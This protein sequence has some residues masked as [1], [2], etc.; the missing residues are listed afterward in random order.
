[1]RKLHRSHVVLAA[2]FVC[3][4]ATAVWF[5][6]SS[7]SAFPWHNGDESNYGLQTM[8]V[9]R[10]EPVETRTPNR[11]LLNPYLLL[12][13]GPFLL[14]AGPS[15]P[16]M[17]APAVVCGL[18]AVILTIVWGARV[19]DRT[20]GLVGGVLVATLPP[21]IF[22]SR[23]GLEQSQLPLFGLFVV[24][25]ALRGHGAGL[26]ATF[27]ASML[28]HPTAIF[29]IP[30]ALP[31]YLVQVARRDE[32]DLRRRRR[33]LIV[34]GVLA[35]G[36]V[37]V[38]SIV[39][40]AHPMTQ[41]RLASR[42]PL[43]WRH[44]LDGCER[45]LFLLYSPTS[46]TNV[47]W[48]RLIFRALL[49][50]LLLLGAGRLV[51]ERRWERVALVGGLAAGLAGFH[52]V[53]GPEV[54]RHEPT[55]RYGVVFLLPTALAFACLIRALVPTVLHTSDVP[56]SPRVR[57]VPLAIALCLGSALLWSGYRNYFGP[58]LREVGESLWTFRQDRRDEYERLLLAI[59]HDR[60]SPE[61]GGDRAGATID[62]T[63]SSLV[64]VGDYWTLKPL[65]YLLCATKD[66]E[67][68][69]LISAE[70][71]GSRSQV[72]LL[73]AKRIELCDRLRHG[74]YVVE[75]LEIAAC[76]G[77]SLTGDA[78]RV[79]FSPGDVRRWFIP[80]RSRHGAGLVL[81]RLEG[82]SSR[83]AAALSAPDGITSGDRR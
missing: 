45:L 42:P 75:R 46:P 78:L 37:A 80:D 63:P 83:I 79:A 5:R 4:F 38:S 71:L 12:L 23:L 27:L 30:I 51:W 64:V 57:P 67:V 61:A 66:A 70:E 8:H 68:T 73:E 2:G 72:E 21:V 82:D 40:L 53:A 15:V 77:G 32:G 20:T 55:S 69:P 36:T 11:S 62:R 48:H 13:Q 25:A 17:R 29:L 44:F 34:S 1:M 43:D 10:G 39:I 52:L 16:V 65:T 33:V 41:L 26:L 50:T 19:L 31:V 7:L 47:R 24:V 74:A 14:V 59:Q 22:Y 54:L 28:V 6:V 35:L 81:Y 76:W 3:L 60:P 18:L 49:A 56:R 9:L 58:K